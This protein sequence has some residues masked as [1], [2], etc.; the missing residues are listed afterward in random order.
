[1]DYH[2]NTMQIPIF[3]LGNEPKMHTHISLI[4]TNVFS[5]RHFNAIHRDRVRSVN[6]GGNSIN[7]PYEV[8][9]GKAYA[10]VISQL[11]T[12]EHGRDVIIVVV[13]CSEETKLNR[14]Q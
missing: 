3:Y 10:V 8:A 9:N 11:R 6:V 13:I 5:S 4:N 14:L 7:Q 12:P 1:M 2:Y